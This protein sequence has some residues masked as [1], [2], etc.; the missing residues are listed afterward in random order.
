MSL[1]RAELARHIQAIECKY[2]SFTN[3]LSLA[4]QYGANNLECL[5]NTAFI[6]KSSLDILRKFYSDGKICTNCTLVGNTYYI[7]KVCTA[8]PGNLYPD[9]PNA[10]T[11]YYQY[12]GA[13]SEVGAGIVQSTDEFGSNLILTGTDGGG[14]PVGPFAYTYDSTTQVLTTDVFGIGSMAFDVTFNDD[15]SEA[16]IIYEDAVGTK[17]EAYV[18]LTSATQDNDCDWAEYCVTEEEI[19]D[20]I[21]TCY[22]KLESV[23]LCK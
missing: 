1:T 17:L 20:L 18:R 12:D 14:N 21:K 5:Q 10:Y 23:C 2:A 4:L 8:D 13:S 3:K 19:E 16:S 22:K 6:V 9:V 11:C 7:Y 15:C